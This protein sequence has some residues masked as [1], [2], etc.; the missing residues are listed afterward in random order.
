MA[1][2]NRREK[3]P[4]RFV[5]MPHKQKN[6]RVMKEKERIRKKT[7]KEEEKIKRS[8]CTPFF[9]GGIGQVQKSRNSITKE[10]LGVGA[11]G[12]WN[13]KEHIVQPITCPFDYGRRKRRGGWGERDVG[14]EN[15]AKGAPNTKSGRKGLLKRVRLRKKDRKKRKK[16]SPTKERDKGFVKREGGPK[17]FRRS[18]TQRR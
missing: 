8:S 11:V 18:R 5:L 1:P 14:P 2:E 16:G 15:L 6:K 4:N 13:E 7:K 9:K 17:R 10:R 12:N 3:V